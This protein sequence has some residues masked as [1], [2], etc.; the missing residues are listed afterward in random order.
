VEKNWVDI[1]MQCDRKLKKTR[2]VTQVE[3]EAKELGKVV[4]KLCTKSEIKEGTIKNEEAAWEVSGMSLARCM[5]LFFLVIC[6][7]VG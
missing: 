1:Q 2:K 7:H 4:I 6:F 3:E 5:C